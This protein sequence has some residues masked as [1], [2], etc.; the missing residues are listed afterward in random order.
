MRR[1][2]ISNISSKG[3]SVFFILA[4]IGAVFM[5][6]YV[7]KKQQD[8]RQRAQTAQAVCGNASSDTMLII[9][10]S[11]SMNNVTSSTDSTTKI[12][13]AKQAADSFVDTMSQDTNNHIGLVSFSDQNSTTLDSP[14]TGAF[15][16]VKSKI[17]A[18]TAKGNTCTQCGIDKS[19]Q[20]IHSDGRAGIKKVAILLTD[21]LANRIENSS[22]TNTATAEQ[23]ALT[24]AINGNTADGTIFY[25]I[26]LGADVNSTFLQNI[27]NQTGGKYYFAPTANDLQTI[28]QS[29]SQIIGKSS[30]NGFVFNDM[31]GN[32]VYD[33]NVD[34]KLAGWVVTLKNSVGTI[35]ASTTTD[36]AGNY[37]F[38]GLCNG[39]YDLSEQVQSGWR[40][41]LPGSPSSYAVTI[42]SPTQSFEYDFGN[43]QIPPTPTALPT[44]TP[45][46]IPTMI[47]VPTSTPV[48]LST[49]L[50]LTLILH[51]IGIGGDNANPTGNSLSNKNPLHPQRDISV[52][53]FD[54]NNN[55]VSSVTG[56]LTYQSSSG[57]FTGLVDMGNSIFSQTAPYTV[58]VKAT[59]FLRRIV[60]GIQTIISG[61]TN[62][63]PT[64]TL[65]AGDVNSDNMLNILD[66]NAILDCGYG[67]LN[68]LPMSDPDSKYNSAECMAHPDRANVDFN[69][70]GTIDATDYN[71]FIRELSVQNGE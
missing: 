58:K 5:T 39:T 28:Y 48:P 30:L 62:A 44:A 2:V 70:D 63:M 26:G 51:S 34:Q 4:L 33:S 69:D 9:D 16:T 67:N 23:A 14:L 50:S 56:N 61:Q 10:K 27:A 24:A 35:V 60:P 66:Y 31:N 41:T 47:P 19:N 55:L 52:Q 40:Q 25:T 32:A 22:T 7:A 29:I 59:Q 46:P 68:P 42:S 53:V 43:Q 15:S 21:G 64:T 12:S 37:T 38:T 71:L 6:V 3:I 45:T 17:D 20:E 57:T 8:L 1:K 54:N 36:S 49:Q 65:I 11:G 18:I 13:R